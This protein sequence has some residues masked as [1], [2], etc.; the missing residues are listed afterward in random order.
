M[1]D[2]F[3]RSIKKK[4]DKDQ[5]KFYIEIFGVSLGYK[6]LLTIFI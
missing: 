3:S 6:C 4:L 5:T 1:D 2:N